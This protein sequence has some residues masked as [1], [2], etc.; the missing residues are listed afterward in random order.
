MKHILAL[1]VAVL[2]AGPDYAAAQSTGGSPNDPNN[3]RNQ[4]PAPSA[5]QPTDP[6]AEYDPLARVPTAPE[7]RIDA[8]DQP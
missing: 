2:I 1:C 7:V 5:S 8:S 3:A 4:F 6:A